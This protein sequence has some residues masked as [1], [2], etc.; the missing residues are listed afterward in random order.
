MQLEVEESKN[1]IESVELHH[2]CSCLRPPSVI[3]WPL[4]QQHQMDFAVHS[5][6]ANPETCAAVLVATLLLLLCLPYK[7]QYSGASTR[8][9][10]PVNINMVSAFLHCTISPTSMTCTMDSLNIEAI[11]EPHH[12]RQQTTFTHP[13][14]I[15]SWS[16]H[17]SKQFLGG[18][19][20]SNG[21]HTTLSLIT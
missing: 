10:S 19:I 13:V 8:R 4:H 15:P 5:Q 2:K 17:W 16:Q 12:L 20:Y 3:K 14:V 1:K 21:L 18:A 9:L 6:A 11:D 7:W